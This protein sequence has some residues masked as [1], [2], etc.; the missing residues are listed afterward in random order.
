MS[1][2]P[3]LQLKPIGS[4]PRVSLVVAWQ[5]SPLELSRRFRLW[6]GTID[7]NVDVVIACA[8][9]ATE[10]QRL[11]RAHPGVRIIPAA[12]ETGMHALRQIGVAAA[13]GDIVVIVDNAISSTPSWRDALAPAVKGSEGGSRGERVGYDH[14]VRMEDA[15]LT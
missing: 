9:A 10:H 11:E 1:E 14:T 2:L 5:G 8:C 15:S 12:P 7:E 3:A 13:Q 6:R 4:R